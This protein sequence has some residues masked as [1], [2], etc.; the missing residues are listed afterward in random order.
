MKPILIIIMLV[1]SAS[2]FAQSTSI[3]GFTYGIS[4]PLGKTKEFVE[5]P[6][7]VGFNLEARR[8]ISKNVLIGF[9]LGWNVFGEEVNG[10]IH[11]ENDQVTGDITGNQGRYINAFPILLNITYAFAKNRASK[12]I[13]YVTMNSGMY[14]IQQRFY[15]GIYQFDNNHT[16]FGVGPE[17]GFMIKSESMNFLFNVRYNYAFDA[18]DRMN[19]DEKNDHSWISFN[20]GIAYNRVNF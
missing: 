14:V 15:I 18:G 4:L 6:S 5:D 16:H 19:G 3:V 13:P 7:F 1:F 8:T 9:S 10:T 11:L 12:F 2:V 17:A 20:M